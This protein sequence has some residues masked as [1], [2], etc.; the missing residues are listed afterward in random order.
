MEAGL[1][2]EKQETWTVFYDAECGFCAWALA[3]LLSCDRA[4]RIRP[5]ALQSYDASRLLADVPPAERM[6]SWHLI[7]PVGVRYS[8]GAAVAPVLRLLAGGRIPATAFARFP[9]LTEK[10]YRWIAEHRSQLSRLVPARA[11]SNARKRVYERMDQV[12]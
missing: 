7:S 9:T 12:N 5:C 4:S 11:K 10:A 6:A 1:A 8:A 2:S 3:T